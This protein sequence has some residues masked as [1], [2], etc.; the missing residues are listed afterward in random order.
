M[1]RKLFKNVLLFDGTGTLPYPGEALIHGNRIETVARG[2][3]QLGADGAQVVDGGGATLMPG[4]TEAHCHLSF[5]NCVL[6]AEMGDL[7]IEEHTLLT[8]KHAKLMLDCGF[9]SCFSAASAKPRLDIVIRN[10]IDAGDIPGPRLRAASPE[11]TATGGLGDVRQL[12][13]DRTSVEII[14]DGADELRRVCRTMIRE[15]VDTLKINLSGDNWIRKGH[16]E[17]L[18]YTDAEVAAAAGQAHESGVTLACHAH[19]NSSVQLALK[20]GFQVIYHAEY[21]DEATLDALE[22][23]K[24]QV[25]LAPTIGS[26]WTYTYE[27]AAWGHTTEKAA[28]N[29]MLETIERACNVYRKMR[30]RGIRALPGGDYGFAWNPIGTNARDLEHFVRLFDYPPAEVLRAATMYG[31]QLMGMGDELGLI[32]PGYLADLL[33]VDG[34]PV[35]D[36]TLLQD[37]ANLLMV[38]KD[39]EYHKAPPPRRM[40]YA[41]TAAE[42][43]RRREA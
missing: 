43:R 13:Q 34:D 36:I 28:R 26:S 41:Q 23:K 9:T 3:D 5:T 25:F 33:M 14:A 4:L 35:K 30:E 1:V 17:E 8:M 27:A 20:Y 32:K 22:A 29:G 18:T 12:H 42:Q 2:R 10:A 37:R 39:G 19:G 11:I 16:S 40:Q 6:V 21:V 7:P 15:G 24:D 38:M 31:G